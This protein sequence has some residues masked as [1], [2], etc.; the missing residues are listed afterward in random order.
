MK[1][2][3]TVICNGKT[4]VIGVTDY[5]SLIAEILKCLDEELASAPDN[6]TIGI[7]IEEVEG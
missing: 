1:R 3:Y 5:Y 7:K 6:I 4:T 2:E